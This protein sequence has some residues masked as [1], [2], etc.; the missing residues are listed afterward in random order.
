M[1]HRLYFTV[2]C[3]IGTLLLAC[4]KDTPT[5]EDDSYTLAIPIGFP[6]PSI[7]EDNQ[8]TKSRIALGKKLF[9]D[10]SLSRD[11][12][13]SCASC[14]KPSL[15]FADDEAFSLGVENRL[16]VR[17]SVSLANVAYQENLL[18]E[19]GVPTLEQQVLV[20]IQ[21]HNEFDFN[22]VLL[23]ER[24]SKDSVYVTLSQ[25]AYDREMSAFVISRA[26][27]AFQ[28]T[29]LSG[30]SPYDQYFF[31]N[32]SNALNESEIRGLNLFN[33][34]A[35]NCSKCHSDFNFTNEDFTNNG[36]YEIYADSGRIR[37]TG[38]EED[39]GIFK[40]PSLRNVALT[41]PYMHDGSMNTL[42]EIIVHYQSGGKNHENKSPLI[43]GFT[44]TDS[45]K[46]DL[47]NFLKSLTDQ[48]FIQ[49]PAF[50]QE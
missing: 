28:R 2:L 5:I 34:D 22:M 15:A 35:L 25:Q 17:N 42:E 32:Q 14:H 44:I 20:P 11:S 1:N 29:L 39:R 16:G 9:F 48:E 33:S 10:T 18:R 12:S 24:L 49:N 36:L 47:V 6:T 41:A 21:D 4:K 23:V 7:P 38:L 27:A 26:L 45:E 46:E 43:Q 3:V 19:G 50:Q 13:V 37:L 8:L 31:Q 30:N 40:V